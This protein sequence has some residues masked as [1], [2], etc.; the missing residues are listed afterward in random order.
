MQEEVKRLR[1][2]LM[3]FHLDFV[4]CKNATKPTATSFLGILLKLYLL[5]MSLTCYS[6]VDHVFGSCANL[7]LSIKG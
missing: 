6:V 2:S 3:L 4:S 5:H 7:T 1:T